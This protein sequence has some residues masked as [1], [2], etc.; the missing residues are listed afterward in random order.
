MPSDQDRQCNHQ[1]FSTG[2]GRSDPYCHRSPGESQNGGEEGH[3]VGVATAAS[4]VNGERDT[5]R[6][7]HCTDEVYHSAFTV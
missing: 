4:K 5:Q 1:R 3:E 2:K 7:A 6:K